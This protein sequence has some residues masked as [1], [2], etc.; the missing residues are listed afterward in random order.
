MRKPATGA[1]WA[2]HVQGGRVGTQGGQDGYRDGCTGRW[3]PGGCT[4][5]GAVLYPRSGPVPSLPQPGPVPSLP[6][7]GPVYVWLCLA[8]VCLA[9][10]CLALV[11]FWSGGLV[12]NGCV[13]A[14]G[15]TE[16][17]VS[18]WELRELPLGKT[19]GNLR[20]DTESSKRHY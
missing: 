6:Q 11:G 7:P 8:L 16:S 10:V 5:V 2:V 17:F 14:G 1:P 15:L 12:L 9:L 3:V 4:G 19:N 18:G 20:L 13:L